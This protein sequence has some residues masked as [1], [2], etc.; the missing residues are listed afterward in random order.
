V[1]G[2]LR[3]V[4]TGDPLRIPARAYNAFV[5][6]AHLARRIDADTGAGPALP[7]AQEHLVLVRNES[8]ADLPRFGIL[9]IDRPII[10]PGAEGNTDEFKRRAALIG[11][12][13]T[14]TDEFVGRFVVAR[15]PIASGKIGWSVIRGVTPATVNVIDEDHS[16]ADTYAGEQVLRSGFTGAA[17][18]LWKEPG[19]GEL[20]A[21]IEMGPADRDRFAAR[22]GTATL[23]DG[24]TFGWLYEWEEVRLDGDPFGSTFGQYVRPGGSASEGWLASDG[25][26]ARLA[27]NRY[28]AHLSMIHAQ[29][30]GTEGFADGGACLIPG[31]LENCPPRRAA[32]PMLHPIPEDIVV[33]LRAERT[34]QG[35][36]RLVFEAL[37]PIVLCDMDVPEWWYG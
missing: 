29:G 31:A 17:R 34:F 28:E 16:H 27:F 9:G 36:T 10:E 2:D 24:R 30:G 12:A 3:K 13:I 8:G 33:E 23:I 5:D 25:D 26:P 7:G 37:N 21:L 15:E 6:A 20:L 32:V 4:R 22:L 18:I 19:T 1:T 35:E 11:A 14:T